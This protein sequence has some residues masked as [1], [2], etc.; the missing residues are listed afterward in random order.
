M[1]GDNAV[2]LDGWQLPARCCGSWFDGRSCPTC[3]HYVKPTVATVDAVLDG[4]GDN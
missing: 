1:V 4:I 3:G 2:A